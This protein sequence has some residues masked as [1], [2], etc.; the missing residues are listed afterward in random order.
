[1]EKNE[2][3]GDKDSL[4]WGSGLSQ[5]ALIATSLHFKRI[6]GEEK[7]LKHTPGECKTRKCP[8]IRLSFPETIQR[9]MSKSKICLLTCV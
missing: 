9:R 8:D 6:S 1:M 4:N 2:Q 3:G 7:T 5:S